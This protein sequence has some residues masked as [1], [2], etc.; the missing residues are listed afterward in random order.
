MLYPQQINRSRICPAYADEELI[1]KYFEGVGV[2][3]ATVNEYINT[4]ECAEIIK[5]LQSLYHPRSMYLFGSYAWGNPGEHSDLD[6]AV[7][8]DHSDEKPYK[9]VHKGIAELWDIHRAIDLLVYTTEEFQTSA[10]H[11][12]T[13][14]HKIEHQGIKMYEAA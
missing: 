6:I 12:S 7:I 14:Q 5:R 10:E 13:L 2:V 1:K 9:R 8:V 3:M 4:A 11:P